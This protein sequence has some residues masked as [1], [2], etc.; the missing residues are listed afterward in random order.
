MFE[1]AAIY[2]STPGT[3]ANTGCFNT[4]NPTSLSYS[5][6]TVGQG[7]TGNI[8]D[9]L[10]FPIGSVDQFLTI[11]GTSPLLDFVLD[12]SSLPTSSTAC[13]AVLGDSCIP[14]AGSPY[15]LTNTVTGATF[16]FAAFGHITDGG[17][18][19]PWSAAFKS[20]IASMTDLAVQTTIVGG[21]TVTTTYSANPLALGV[22]EPGT[23]A[24]VL[25]GGL[26]LLGIGRQL[27]KT[28]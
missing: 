25:F 8:K 28:A 2:W 10:S 9:L 18:T 20:P 1:E 4:T 14:F 13:D 11:L 12:G 19:E 23:V 3:V 5:G 21:G 15:Y 6:G 7:A 24:T 17:V 26:A 22:P 16:T 27:R